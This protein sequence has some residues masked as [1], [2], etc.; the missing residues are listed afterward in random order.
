[1]KVSFFMKRKKRKF[2]SLWKE[3]NYKVSR[4]PPPKKLYCGT[5]A[6]LI[7]IKIVIKRSIIIDLLPI[8]INIDVAAVK[9]Y[10][11]IHDNSFHFFL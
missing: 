8:K 10:F 7:W 9:I 6:I 5:L 2:L 3:R 11:V 1:M 4:S